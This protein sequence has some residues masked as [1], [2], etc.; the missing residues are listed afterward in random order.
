MRLKSLVAV[1]ALATGMG[2]AASAN[3]GII[4]IAGSSEGVFSDGVGGSIVNTLNNGANTRFKWGSNGTSM[5]TAID[6]DIEVFLDPNDPDLSTAH[7][8]TIGKLR[9]FNAVS[10]QVEH[11]T[12]VKYTLTVNFT[13]PNASSDSVTFD[14][15]IENT[16]NSSNPSGDKI[17]GLLL[18]TLGELEFDLDGVIVSNLHF[19]PQDHGGNNC[20]GADTQYSGGTLWYNCESNT[21]DLRIVADFQAVPEP[22]TVALLGMG[23]LGLGVA[24]RRMATKA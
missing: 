3:A 15:S 16:P 24:R 22:A 17:T 14:L 11:P 5:L 1:A 23:L 7:D 9:W 12:S 13:A 21:A 4:D 8:V 20:S 18:A 6:W 2:Y 19:A 10:S